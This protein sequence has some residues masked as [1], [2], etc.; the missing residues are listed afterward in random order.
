MKSLHARRDR[1]TIANS[2]LD[3]EIKAMVIFAPKK[4]LNTHRQFF[5]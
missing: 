5:F 1:G 4:P 2:A 3:D